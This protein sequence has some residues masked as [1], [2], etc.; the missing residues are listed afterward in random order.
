MVDKSTAL[1][2]EPQSMKIYEDN[3]RFYDVLWSHIDKARDVI[4]IV[5]YDMDH[6]NIAGI[7]L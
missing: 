5:T 6:K 3:D 7:T 1:D 2:Q 4:C